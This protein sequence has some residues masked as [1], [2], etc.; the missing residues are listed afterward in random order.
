M[1]FTLVAAKCDGLLG[2]LGSLFLIYRDPTGHLH[3]RDPTGEGIVDAGM[4][5]GLDQGSL[6]SG[7][8]AEAS[9]GIWSGQR[10]VRML[11]QSEEGLGSQRDLGQSVKNKKAH[12]TG[13]GGPQ[14]LT[15]E[16]ARD[17]KKS[18]QGSQLLDRMTKKLS[19]SKFR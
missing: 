18:Q 3:Y 19:G 8:P 12:K 5:K 13:A 1:S 6:P 15:S 4:A 7:H 2:L 10:G 11:D 17:V 9:E 16:P 14:D